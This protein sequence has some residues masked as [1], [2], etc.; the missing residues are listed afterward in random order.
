M[1]SSEDCAG[2]LSRVAARLQ[3]APKCVER[4]IPKRKTLNPKLHVQSTE[5]LD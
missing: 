5:E 2:A 1:A 4:Y 3:E